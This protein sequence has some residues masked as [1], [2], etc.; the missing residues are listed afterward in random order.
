MQ[1]A[2][3]FAD[4]TVV[5]LSEFGYP[6]GWDGVSTY[7]WENSVPVGYGG[8]SLGTFLRADF[9]PVVQSNYAYQAFNV[10]WWDHSTQSW[11]SS[12]GVPWLLPGDLGGEPYF[13]SYIAQAI[14]EGAVSY[15][16]PVHITELP[17][18]H[19]VRYMATSSRMRDSTA[20][21]V[22]PSPAN[23]DEYSKAWLDEF[24]LKDFTVRPSRYRYLILTEP[25][26]G[27]GWSVGKVR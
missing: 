9:A 10:E 14:G 20:E 21:I 13:V 27:I 8:R 5:L 26:G 7:E 16:E 4:Y 23:G 1:Q 22:D 12:A 18:D 25:G 3:Y 17:A 6:P 2:W 19:K 24:P 15:D 11:S